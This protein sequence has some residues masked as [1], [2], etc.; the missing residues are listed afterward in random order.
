MKR[1][2]QNKK[3]LEHLKK[4]GSITTLAAYDQYRIT[5]LS[6]R[7]WDLRNKGYPIDTVYYTVNDR[8][9]DTVRFGRY[10]LKDELE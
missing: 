1:P 8:N 6:A 9:G 10:F 2:S 5:R 3:V 4:Y 7:I